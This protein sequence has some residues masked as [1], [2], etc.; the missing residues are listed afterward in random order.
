MASGENGDGR[1]GM[2]VRCMFLLANLGDVRWSWAAS[3]LAVRKREGLKWCQ[4]QAC[5]LRKEKYQ[6]VVPLKQQEP[7]VCGLEEEFT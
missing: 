6:L 7:R 3:W 4:P 5:L 1:L 2:W